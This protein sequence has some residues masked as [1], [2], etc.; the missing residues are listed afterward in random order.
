MSDL[1]WARTEETRQWWGMMRECPCWTTQVVAVAPKQPPDVTELHKLRRLH[2]LASLSSHPAL[3]NMNYFCI[4]EDESNAL[5]HTK[6]F[7]YNILI[8][9][10][11][12]LV[13]NIIIPWGLNFF[14]LL[15]THI[16]ICV[17]CTAVNSTHC[18]QPLPPP[19]PINIF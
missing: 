8:L 10:R 2:R 15:I 19:H 6:Y 1:M 4:L 18:S 5:D 9:Y 11:R 3:C 7:L 16:P 13:V 14:R 12:H 17:S